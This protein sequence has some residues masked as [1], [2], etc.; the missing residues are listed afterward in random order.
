MQFLRSESE[1]SGKKKEE[2]I[3]N[4][5]PATPALGDEEVSTCTR[6]RW[7]GEMSRDKETLRRYAVLV[8]GG[9]AAGERRGR[10]HGTTRTR[11]PCLRACSACGRSAMW[12]GCG[13]VPR[14]EFTSRSSRIHVDCVARRYLFQSACEELVS[15]TVH[16]LGSQKVIT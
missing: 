3:T 11:W 1:S 2:Q 14:V 7:W 10:R 16:K 13:G 9:A 6:R 8:L 4:S 15:I 5:L 12:C